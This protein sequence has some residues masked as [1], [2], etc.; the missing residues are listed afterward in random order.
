[1]L[2]ERLPGK[3]GNLTVTIQ[4]VQMADRAALAVFELAA[5]GLL[6][7][8][9]TI[10]STVGHHDQFGIYPRMVLTDISVGPGLVERYIGLLSGADRAGSPRPILRDHGVRHFPV[11]HPAHSRAY[12][13]PRAVGIKPVFI[14]VVSVPT[15]KYPVTIKGHGFN[16][17][18]V[19]NWSNERVIR[20]SNQRHRSGLQRSTQLE[21][22]YRGPS[23]YRNVL[24][25]LYFIG[26]SR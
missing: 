10:L 4:V 22:P 7:G 19:C 2:Q 18:R 20:R 5:L 11:V 14:N 16:F 25:P 12:F 26:S 8:I 17:M 1:M 6:L 24:F 15:R 9:N 21:R 13:H 3:G 23:C